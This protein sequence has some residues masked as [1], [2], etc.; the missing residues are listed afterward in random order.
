MG[1][2][3]REKKRVR[4]SYTDVF[5]KHRQRRAPA[6]AAENKTKY[7]SGLKIK[8][9]DKSKNIFPAYSCKEFFEIIA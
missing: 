1:K 5:A 8:L 9:I 2:W 3:K 4:I 7:N 6:A